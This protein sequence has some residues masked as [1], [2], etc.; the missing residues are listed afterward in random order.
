VVCAG[1]CVC[2]VRVCVGCAG[3]C[4]CGCVCGW[5]CVWCVCVGVCG[6]VWVCVCVGVCGCVGGGWCGGVG[7]GG[8]GVWGVRNL[9]SR[10]PFHS[11]MYVCACRVAQ[12]NAWKVHFFLD[13]VTN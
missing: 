10:D 9:F 12:L 8:V 13:I 11:C 6:C 1:V 7:G 3:V 4:V 5:V 2:G